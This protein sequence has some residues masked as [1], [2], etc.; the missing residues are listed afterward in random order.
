MADVAGQAK[1][2]HYVGKR[3]ELARL[4]HFAQVHAQYVLAMPSIQ[5]NVWPKHLA[6]LARCGF[7]A[8]AQHYQAVARFREKLGAL[9]VQ[10]FQIDLVGR[11]QRPEA[12]AR[13]WPV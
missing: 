12:A 2:L 6:L 9:A 7:V 4:H 10:P 13:H 3:D 11:V 1:A 5:N 8:L